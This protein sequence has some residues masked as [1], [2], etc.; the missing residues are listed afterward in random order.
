[1]RSVAN[2]FRFRI[3]WGE[4][5]CVGTSCRP[6]FGFRFRFSILAVSCLPLLEPILPPSSDVARPARVVAFAFLSRF[7]PVGRIP[8]HRAEYRALPPS[9]PATPFPFWFFSRGNPKK[10]WAAGGRGGRKERSKKLLW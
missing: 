10:E 2:P 1:M 6:H 7:E 4:Y 9:A 3:F 5:I 8:P